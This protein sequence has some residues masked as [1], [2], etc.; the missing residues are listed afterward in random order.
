MVATGSAVTYTSEESR[1]PLFIS[2]RRTPTPLARVGDGFCIVP[3]P[4]PAVR[5]AASRTMNA[6]IPHAGKGRTVSNE[7]RLQ[8]GQE[9][10]AGYKLLQMRGRGSF[11]SVWEASTAT[12]Q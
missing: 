8:V 11:G 12:G 9:I 10:I 3:G 1:T 7:P 5:P 2:P 6:H 4:N